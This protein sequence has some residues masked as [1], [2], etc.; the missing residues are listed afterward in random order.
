MTKL[1]T[2]KEFDQAWKATQKSAIGFQYLNGEYK[3]ICRW[4]LGFVN[5]LPKIEKAMEN[6]EYLSYCQG[7]Q[8]YVKILEGMPGAGYAVSAFHASNG[9]ADR[10]RRAAASSTG[11]TVTTGGC[12]AGA[13]I[14][15]AIAP[16]VGTLLGGLIGGA[17][18]GAGGT[19]AKKGINHSIEDE[20]MRK[21]AGTLSE[22]TAKDLAFDATVGAVFGSF[23]GVA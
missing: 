11:A 8:T 20:G 3:E 17:F 18:G 5:V 21:K 13:A 2:I 14:G 4:N 19:I 10:A 9:D 1:T 12:V 6:K 16:G 23:T 22:M 15:T 7:D